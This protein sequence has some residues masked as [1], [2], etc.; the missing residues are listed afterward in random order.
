MIRRICVTLIK[1]VRKCV[2]NSLECY[3]L[4]P[5]FKKWLLIK[6]TAMKCTWFALN[7][8]EHHFVNAF[9]VCP[10]FIAMN[11]ALLRVQKLDVYECADA[12]HT[13]SSSAPFGSGI[14]SCLYRIH[15]LP[16][17]SIS[18][19]LLFHIFCLLLTQYTIFL[20]NDWRSEWD[21]MA[22]GEWMKWALASLHV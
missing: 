19:M 4:T 15:S 14:Y 3:S 20:C 21:G 22:T 7:L 9:D 1:C 18:S 8:F 10:I 5:H 16:I 17:S 12:C 11:S 6:R 13:F 2:R